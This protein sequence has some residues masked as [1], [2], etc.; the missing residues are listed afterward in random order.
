MAAL[1]AA[2]A[3]RERNKAATIEIITNEELP[4]YNRPMLTKNI[5]AKPDVLG[6][7]T[8]SPEWYVENNIAVTFGTS[9]TRIDGGTKIAELSDGTSRKYDRLVY[10]A[11]AESFVPPI[12]GADQPMVRVIRKVTDIIAIQNMLPGVQDIVMIGGGVLGLEAASEFVKT[13]RKV[14][15]VE[16]APALMGRQLDETGSRFLKAA[17]EAKGIRVIT[18]AK[19]TGIDA[20]GVQLETEKLP[21]QLVILSTGTKANVQV[22]QSAGASVERFVNVNEKMETSLPDVYA[23]GDVAACSGVSIGIWN[24]AVEMGRVAGANAAGDSLVYEGITPAVSFTGFGIE[25][26]ALGDNGKKEGEIYKTIEVD[27]PRMLTYRKFYF[28]HDIFVGAVLIGD[29]SISAK[30]MEAYQSQADTETLIA[31]L[32]GGK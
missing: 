1:T 12:P 29:T 11:G 28:L 25:L 13:G 21:A 19:I 8:K 32:H 15:I 27:D 22:L 10:A 24:Q 9:V 14:S 4:C 20:D 7:I 30:V 3:A 6:F 18:G 31:L 5:L 17:A 16:M 26:F 2:E 23:A